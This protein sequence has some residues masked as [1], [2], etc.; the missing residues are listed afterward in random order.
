MNQQETLKITLG[1][2]E[3]AVINGLCADL[4]MYSWNGIAFQT[5]QFYDEDAC[6]SVFW[7]FDDDGYEFAQYM[8][9]DT[10]LSEA[11]T[12][13]MDQLRTEGVCCDM[14]EAANRSFP[15]IHEDY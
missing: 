6:A 10:P 8:G 14:V 4:P 9:G 2:G 12:I 11:P 1:D 3:A 5:G 15:A 7:D 13:L